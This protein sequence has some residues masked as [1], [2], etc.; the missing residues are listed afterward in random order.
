MLICLQGKQLRSMLD[1]KGV[2]CKGCSE[3]IDFVNRVFETQG[4]PDVEPPKPI[5]E[6]GK[7]LDKEKIDEV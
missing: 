6:E 4:L 2:V 5:V 7:G 1:K 3:K